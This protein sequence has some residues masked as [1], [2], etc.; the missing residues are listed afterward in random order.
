MKKADA[1]YEISAVA[2]SYEALFLLARVARRFG[3]EPE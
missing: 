2:S 1:W 3:R